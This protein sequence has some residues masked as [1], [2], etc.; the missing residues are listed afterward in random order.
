M[1]LHVSYLDN[2]PTPSVFSIPLSK[3]PGGSTREATIVVDP[4][5]PDRAAMF[6]EGYEFDPDNVPTPEK[7][8]ISLNLSLAEA[9]ELARRL[10]L[11]VQ[12]AKQGEFSG[13]G[14][15]LNRHTRETR[16]KESW[17]ALMADDRDE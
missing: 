3:S 14:E 13:M 10:V 4:F 12:A 2:E 11:V 6:E 7:A 16:L 8:G 15:E 5:G 9:E 17:D 1:F